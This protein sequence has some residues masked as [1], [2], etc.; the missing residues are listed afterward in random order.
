M[1]EFVPRRQKRRDLLAVMGRDADALLHF[2]CDTRPVP[3][4]DEPAGLEPSVCVTR[5]SGLHLYDNCWNV[6]SAF[7]TNENSV[8]DPIVPLIAMLQLPTRDQQ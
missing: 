2:L 3:P 1:K 8:K 5:S 6:T 4:I 7:E